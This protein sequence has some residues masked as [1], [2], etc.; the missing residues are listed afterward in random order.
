MERRREWSG[1]RKEYA[2]GGG[3]RGP[4]GV[5]G[6]TPPPLPP[7][8]R[9]GQPLQPTAG[10]AGQF[11]GSQ[12]GEDWLRATYA[13]LAGVL[14]CAGPLWSHAQGRTRHRDGP[15]AACGTPSPSTAPQLTQLPAQRT[16]RP[17][18]VEESEGQLRQ[19]ARQHPRRHRVGSRLLL[20]TQQ[21]QLRADPHRRPKQAAE[22]Q[23]GSG[24]IGVQGFPCLPP[25]MRQQ[26]RNRAAV[27]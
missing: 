12:T 1:R 4:G 17:Q 6:Q 21:R 14:C 7:P 3:L 10:G 26:G 15:R 8:S 22:L 2:V 16:C 23:Q 27:D 9:N 25:R 24:G 20:G 11:G 18:I 13:G 19:H 5:E